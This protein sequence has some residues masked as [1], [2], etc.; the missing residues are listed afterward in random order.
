[1]NFELTCGTSADHRAARRSDQS[2]KEATARSANRRLPVNFK[3]LIR[4]LTIG[5]HARQ[6]WFPWRPICFRFRVRCGGKTIWSPPVCQTDFL[7][8]AVLQS[9]AQVLGSVQRW[10]SSLWIKLPGVAGGLHDARGSDRRSVT[11]RLRHGR[12]AVFCAIPKFFSLPKL[13]YTEKNRR[14]ES[15][16]SDAQGRWYRNKKS[17][18]EKAE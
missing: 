6:R 9:C 4:R 5:G 14:P 3:A 15:A 16:C 11:N 18:D 2:H 13:N 7:H 10:L 17:E 8:L 1:M 12:F